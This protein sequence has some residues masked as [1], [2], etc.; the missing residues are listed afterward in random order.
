MRN[1]LDMKIF[2]LLIAHF[3][4]T[5]ATLLGSGG[6]KTLVAESLLLKKQLLLVNRTRKRA[7]WVPKTSWPS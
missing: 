1:L 2:L 3:L 6:S 7:L 5:V 4:R